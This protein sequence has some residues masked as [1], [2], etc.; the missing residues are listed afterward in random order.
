MSWAGVHSENVAS[1]WLAAHLCDHLDPV[2]FREVAER[3]GLVPEKT[4]SD[5][6]P[7]TAYRNRMR[8]KYGI[9]INDTVL[10]AAAYN[11][12]VSNLEADF[13]FEDML[14]E[15]KILKKLH[16]GIG[17]EKIRDNVYQA[18][19]SGQ[20]GSFANDRKELSL[21]QG[22]LSQSF[23]ALADLRRKLQ[24]GAMAEGVV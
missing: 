10:R 1:V 11:V 14:D 16:Y 22:I 5:E 3:L 15:Y 13:I 20:A 4:G 7:Y 9:Q 2:Q 8:D 18:F 24:A 6:E 12:A 21:R 17:F 19:A 23:L